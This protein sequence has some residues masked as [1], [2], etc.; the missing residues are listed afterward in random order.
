MQERAMAW[1]RREQDLLEEIRQQR[2]A[3]EAAE[4]TN[5]VVLPQPAVLPPRPIQLVQ[6]PRNQPQNF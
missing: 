1:V 4:A 3:R 6:P 5:P 2:E